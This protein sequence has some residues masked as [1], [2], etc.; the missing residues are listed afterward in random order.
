MEERGAVG[1]CAFHGPAA[2]ENGGQ[3]LK[4]REAKRGVKFA[5]RSS[6]RKSVPVAGIAPEL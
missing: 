6:H 4:L 3:A 2:G 5:I 1:Q